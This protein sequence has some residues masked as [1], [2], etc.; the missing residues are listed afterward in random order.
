MDALDILYL[1]SMSKIISMLNRQVG[2]PQERSF[3]CI[4]R[5][6]KCTF[7]NN[8]Y[9]KGVVG[10]LAERGYDIFLFKAWT[11]HALKRKLTPNFFI[12]L[13]HLVPVVPVS[14]LGLSCLKSY[15]QLS[16]G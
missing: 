4:A 7:K 10:D 5:C 2:S 12:F 6:F 9:Q 3:I 1:Y 15:R 11:L 13:S 16:C 14:C 8:Y